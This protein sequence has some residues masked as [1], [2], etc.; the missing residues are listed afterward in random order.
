M[1]ETKQIILPITGMTCAHCVVTI[2]RNLKKLDGL[3]TAVVNL[4]SERGTIEYDP[5][6]LTLHDIITRIESVGYG[7]ATGEAELAIQDLSNANNAG[8]LEK[9]LAK[10]NGILE[11]QVSL[12]SEKA[13]VKYVPT[14]I[15]QAEIRRSLREA[16]F[17]TIEQGGETED[18]EAL[19][20]E[21]EISEQRRLLII[22]II[23]TLPL[24]LLSMGKDF[25]LLP[26]F[27]Y[28]PNHNEMAAAMGGMHPSQPWFNWLLLLLATPVQFY[29]GWQYYVGAFKSLRNGSPNMDVL[30]A[31]G[32]S[33]AFAYSLPV[34]FGWLDGFVYFE[35][36]AVIITLIRLGKFLEA[37]AKGRTSDAIKKLMGLRA[38]TA[39]IVRDGSEL[40]VPVDQVLVGDIVLVRGRAQCLRPGPDRPGHQVR[41]H[42]ARCERSWRAVP[43]VF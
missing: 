17:E 38:K 22:G 21:R 37:R 24:F 35:T 16:G 43:S 9:S 25:G 32:S 41:F 40:D 10:L 14:I 8:R 29:V 42:R 13:L 23:F 33:V 20:R 6:V 12:T 19:A 1:T 2:E 28:L 27:F 7:I 31:M 11:Y 36:A 34:T 26:D 39:R 15:S 30:I 5:S 18:T 4:S 3:Q